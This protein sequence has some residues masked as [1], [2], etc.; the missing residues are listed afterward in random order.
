MPQRR[1]ME[2][3]L[4]QTRTRTYRNRLRKQA[5]KQS[6]R[7]AL[8]AAWAGDAEVA[9]A[10]LETAQKAIDKAAQRNVYHKNKAAREKSQL[11]T[12]ACGILADQ[13]TS[14]EAD[15]PGRTKRRPGLR[16]REKGER[17][18]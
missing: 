10:A 12:L 13:S 3:H 16:V 6:K 9:Q 18:Q 8:D 15:Y 7:E 2:K 11:T 14:R 17:Q 5:V 1:A 4:R